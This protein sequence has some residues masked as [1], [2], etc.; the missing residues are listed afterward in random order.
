MVRIKDVI[1]DSTL[2]L[3]L[4]FLRF[5]EGVVPEVATYTLLGQ[6]ELSPSSWT[7][8]TSGDLDLSSTV[9]L[10]ISGEFLGLQAGLNLNRMVVFQWVVSGSPFREIVSFQIQ[11]V[12]YVE[13]P[14]IPE[15]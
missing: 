15:P 9:N 8:I 14:E 7:E 13:A 6:N 12:P 11:P 1:A 4:S 3:E 2:D 10:S 5:S